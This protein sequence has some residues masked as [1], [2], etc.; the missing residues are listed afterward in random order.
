MTGGNPGDYKVVGS[1]GWKVGADGMPSYSCYGLTLR[2][3]IDLPELSLVADDQSAPTD[4]TIKWGAA[5]APATA[6]EVALRPVARRIFV[7][8]LGAGSGRLRR[9]WRR[10]HHR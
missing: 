2:S 4:I 5:G 1:F 3:E 10:D 6:T 9:P 8:R 7:W